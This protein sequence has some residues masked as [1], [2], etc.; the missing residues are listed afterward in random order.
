MEIHYSTEKVNKVLELSMQQM[1]FDVR[2]S[3]LIG[4]QTKQLLCKIVSINTI[5]VIQ[6]L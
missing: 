5:R 3:T 2:A 1:E 4:F 6:I